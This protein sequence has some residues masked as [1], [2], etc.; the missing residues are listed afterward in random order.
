M[1]K[2][3]HKTI[4]SIKLAN[5]LLKEGFT[6]YKILPHKD[7]PREAVFIFENAENLGQAIKDYAKMQEESAK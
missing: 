2:K 3:Y 4:F 7:N 5:Y 1:Q 6:I